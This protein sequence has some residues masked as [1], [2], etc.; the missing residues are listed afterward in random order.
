MEFVDIP[1]LQMMLLTIVFLSLFVEIKMGGMGPD[2]H[3]PIGYCV[4]SYRDFAANGGTSGR[5]RCRGHA[6][7]CG[8]GS[9]R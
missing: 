5:T 9:W 3:I 2:W 4:Y 1:I 8:A 6:L 7:Q